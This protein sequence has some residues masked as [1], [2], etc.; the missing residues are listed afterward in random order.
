[1]SARNSLALSYREPLN[2]PGSLRDAD[3]CV[4]PKAKTI[5][6]PADKPLLDQFGAAVVECS[7][8]RIEEVPFAK[9]GG[10][11]E[12][13]RTG[14][15]SPGIAIPLTI[16][17]SAV[18]LARKSYKLWPPVATELCRGTGIMF[19]HLWPPGLGGRYPL[20]LLIWRSFS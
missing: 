4:R 9:I 19:L 1:M 7:W 5:I 2:S 15:S 16:F 12:R 8:K 14:N 13:L 6:S 3:G 17:S 18:P 11:C 10:K 20:D